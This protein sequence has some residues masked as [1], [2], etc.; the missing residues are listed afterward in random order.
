[1][2]NLRVGAGVWTRTWDDAA[3]KG[4]EL[5]PSS[6]TRKRRPVE[7]S[8][9]CHCLVLGT[10]Q[11]EA[12]WIRMRLFHL[13]CFLLRNSLMFASQRGILPASEHKAV[14]PGKAEIK[15]ELQGWK[16]KLWGRKAHWGHGIQH[17]DI[18]QAQGLAAAFLHLWGPHWTYNM[19]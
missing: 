7:G 12:K 17:G 11:S 5:S 10:G 2:K 14:W 4:R 9:H 3:G 13:S 18:P 19:E 8:G 16:M 15:A 6:R 1:M